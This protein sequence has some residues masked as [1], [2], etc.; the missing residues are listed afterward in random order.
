M[1]IGIF[2]VA[3]V[4]GAVALAVDLS[5]MWI[6]PLRKWLADLKAE[7]PVAETRTAEP[8]RQ[9]SAKVTAAQRERTEAAAEVA[10]QETALAQRKRILE[11]SLADAER[12]A[13][14]AA[15]QIEAR[16]AVLADPGGRATT[17][18]KANWKP[19]PVGRRA[20]ARVDQDQ[21]RPQG[22]LRKAWARLSPTGGKSSSAV[23]SRRRNETPR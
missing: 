10:K 7:L 5:S 1:M 19:A 20:R 21:S 23:H 8:E 11:Q 2:A 3:L 4:V 15:A 16:E 13:A 12:R 17:G 14:E 6:P 22:G 18:T 9:M